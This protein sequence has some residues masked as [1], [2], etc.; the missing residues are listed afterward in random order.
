MIHTETSIVTRRWY[1]VIFGPHFRRALDG[2]EEGVI[3]WYVEETDLFD[4]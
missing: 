1:K 3:G 4:C 2:K